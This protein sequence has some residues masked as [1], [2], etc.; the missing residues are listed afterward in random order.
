MIITT[1]QSI[2]GRKT[3]AYH[4]VVVGEAIMGANVARNLFAGMTDI[5][6]S[7]SGAYKQKLLD[8]REIAFTE[9]EERAQRAGADA[10]VDLDDIQGGRRS[11]VLLPPARHGR[12]RGRGAGR[13]R[14]L[15]GSAAE[16]TD[17]IC[18][19]SAET[20]GDFAGRVGGLIPPK[21][22]RIVK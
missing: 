9:L 2:E 7:R 15:Q 13:E 19:R 10:V 20:C 16:T 5:V 4:G 3:S 12:G 17:G 6:G 1:T 22:R 21:K 11:A 18:G 14:V 8:A